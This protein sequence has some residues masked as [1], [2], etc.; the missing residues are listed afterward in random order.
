ME[1]K[2]LNIWFISFFIVMFLQV[3]LLIKKR[4]LKTNIKGAFIKKIFFLSLFA[5]IKTISYFVFMVLSPRFLNKEKE[6]N[7]PPKRKKILN[8]LKQL[9]YS[10]DSFFQYIIFFFTSL[11]TIQERVLQKE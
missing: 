5:K 1:S 2:C 10:K 8:L 3:M 11:P 6:M 9:F 4:F 7:L